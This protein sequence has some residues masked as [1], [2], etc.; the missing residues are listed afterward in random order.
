MAA[1]EEIRKNQEELAA[2]AD[3]C[4]AGV[5]LTPIPELREI[6]L[7]SIT[8]MAALGNLARREAEQ[9]GQRPVSRQ[10]QLLRALWPP[11]V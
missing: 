2:W 5:V 6:G 9:A 1:Q 11:Q 3:W 7:Q 10:L 8:E 4:S